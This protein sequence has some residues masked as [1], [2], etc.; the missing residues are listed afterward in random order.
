MLSDFTEGGG[1]PTAV[2][3]IGAMAAGANFVVI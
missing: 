1:M 3:S 2:F